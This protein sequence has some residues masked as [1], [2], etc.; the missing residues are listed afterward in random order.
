MEFPKL[1]KQ[2]AALPDSLTKING[3]DYVFCVMLINSNGESIRL[4]NKFIRNL[5]INDNILSPFSSGAIILDNR[6]DTLENFHISSILPGMTETDRPVSFK[7]NNDGYDLAVVKI[8]P[9]FS[10]PAAPPGID[11][12]MFPEE[13]WELSYIFTVYDEDEQE[14]TTSVDKKYKILHLRDFKE[15]ILSQ[16]YLNWSTSHLQKELDIS[17]RDL[18]QSSNSNRSIYTGVCIKNII[19]K[20]FKD[21]KFLNEKIKNEFEDDWE[22]GGTKEFYSSPVNNSAIDDIEYFLDRTCSAEI[23]DNCLLR[24]E[25]HKKWSLRPISN[26]F[27]RAVKKSEKKP[28][29]FH[30]DILPVA[31]QKGPD[32]PLNF[33]VIRGLTRNSFNLKM[34]VNQ[35][36]GLANYSFSS[37]TTRDSIEELISAPVHSYNIRNKTFGLDV[38][39]NHID[40]IS[41]KFQEYYVK[42]MYGEKPSL[43][44]PYSE[45]KKTNRLINNQFSGSS[46]PVKRMLVGRNRVLEK[47]LSL[48]SGLSFSMDGLTYRRAGRF[49][50]IISTQNVPDVPF[51]DIFQGE[52]LITNVTHTFTGGVYKNNI[53]CVKPYSFKEVYKQNL[54]PTNI[55]KLL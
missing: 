1:F 55:S 22:N 38:E 40:E 3:N 2:I 30:I 17:E 8:K 25:R 11:E 34:D 50:S 47:L 7:F 20:T 37:T 5:V 24:Y 23:F 42:R 13:V 6:L 29:D 48:N 35:L 27:K 46:N 54:T 21:K 53:T 31:D 44:L 16:T 52:W 28:G 33:G 10:N 32:D 12:K 26:Y 45:D 51:Q 36:A 49:M 15:Q 18:T 43:I 39:D 9:I 19:E 14:I 41:K 4:P